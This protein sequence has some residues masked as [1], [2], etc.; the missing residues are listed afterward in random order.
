[1]KKIIRLFAITIF[2]VFTFPFFQMCSDKSILKQ[3][4]PDETIV[5]SSL[6]RELLKQKNDSLKI[7]NKQYR[8]TKFENV[9]NQWTVNA[10]QLGFSG[11]ADLK[12]SDLDDS[13]LYISL[14]FTIVIL[15]S[16]VIL[17][18]TF[19]ENYL[20]VLRISV[21][22]VI[23]LIV[24]VVIFI[25]RGLDDLRQIKYGYYFLLLNILI[26]VILSK[27]QLNRTATNSR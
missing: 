14:C 27:R 3:Q 21:L 26:L 15:L 22:N 18:L 11:Y 17:Y 19:K 10:Y 24:S 23:L 5:D 20:Y 13:T 2:I 8:D 16:I 7:V 6:S 9:R 1:M 12:F 25:F 4:F